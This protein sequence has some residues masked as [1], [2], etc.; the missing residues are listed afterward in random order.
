MET[1]EEVGWLAAL[2]LQVFVAKWEYY[3]IAKYSRAL[4]L[5]LRGRHFPLQQQ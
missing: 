2:T 3:S 4:C 1:T 5:R